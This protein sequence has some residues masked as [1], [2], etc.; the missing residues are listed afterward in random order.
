MVVVITVIVIVRIILRMRGISGMFIS[1]AI[2]RFC[3]DDAIDTLRQ[4]TPWLH[5]SIT[6]FKTAF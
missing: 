5:I 4:E 6:L 1:M 2:K 3:R